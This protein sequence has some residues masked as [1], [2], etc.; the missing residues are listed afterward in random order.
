[1]KTFLDEFDHEKLNT[2]FVDAIGRP[3]YVGD[4]IVGS[5]SYV[6]KIY[7]GIVTGNTLK[8]LSCTGGFIG[9]KGFAIITDSVLTHNPKLYLDA[10]NRAE[11][12]IRANIKKK[13]QKETKSFTN[14]C[15]KI[16]DGDKFGYALVRYEETT[17][18]S[19]AFFCGV[20]NRELGTNISSDPQKII[21]NNRL[22]MDDKG[23][24]ISKRTSYSN[25]IRFKRL[26]AL[27]PFECNSW[28]TKPVYRDAL[29]SYLVDNNNIQYIENDGKII[30]FYPPKMLFNST[31]DML[32][33][34]LQN[35]NI[36]YHHISSDA[37]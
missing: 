29:A 31:M 10:L 17:D 15:I 4:M 16:T 1:M 18:R 2:G 30:M 5:T 32:K 33:Y 28:D 34:I 19:L 20:I 26:D 9:N 35:K 8:Q 23:T 25:S 22:R 14:H 27:V 21:F 37:L 13:P 11:A 7:T 6:S 36:D 12:E 3:A 24:I